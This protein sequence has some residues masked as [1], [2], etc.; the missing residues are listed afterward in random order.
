MV[1]QNVVSLFEYEGVSDN[2]TATILLHYKNINTI[3]HLRVSNE[4]EMRQSLYI[5][6]INPT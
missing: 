1:I 3:K 4:E 2:I 6:K 5:C